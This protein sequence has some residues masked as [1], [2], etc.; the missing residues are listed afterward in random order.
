MVDDARSMAAM[1]M[2]WSVVG[3]KL[4]FEAE[5]R[6]VEANH[7]RPLLVELGHRHP[8]LEAHSQCGRRPNTAPLAHVSAYRPVNGYGPMIGRPCPN[9]LHL[10]VLSLLCSTHDD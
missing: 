4:S 9:L 5:W 1:A 3:I 2:R 6:C 8:G 7:S 10:R